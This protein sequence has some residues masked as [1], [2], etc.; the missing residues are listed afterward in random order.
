MR[1]GPIEDFGAW[2]E[3]AKEKIDG[4]IV[5]ASISGGKDSTAL[6]LLLNAAGIPY[7]A[8][9]MD[10]GWEH[11]DTEQYVRQYL[12][13]VLGK[14]IE[15][16]QGRHG[17][18]ESLI[19]KKGTF[20]SRVRRYCTQELKVRPMKKWLKSLD[21]EP[22]N[23]VGIRAAESR[24]RSKMPE[25]DHSA[26]FD[27]EVWRPL[28]DWSER[29]VINIHSDFGVLPNPLYL[30][31]ANRVGCWP[32]IF[33]RKKEIRF[34]ANTDPERIEKI[35]QLED[36][37]HQLARAR[38]RARNESLDVLDA[39]PPTWFH[40]R[41]AKRDANGK[42]EGTNWPIEKAVEWS[43]TSWGGK[44]FELFQADESDAGC[45]RWGLC[46]TV[47]ADGDMGWSKEPKE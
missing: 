37:V 18:M 45:M 34:I 4:R 9:H 19:R 3:K 5:C 21:D 33:A 26:G 11:E 15:I 2:T 46:E 25:W 17:G 42:I 10:T 23:V 38:Y 16:I 27:C 24:A 32:C 13:G 47:A 8:V 40:S 12:P 6:G 20:P 41:D 31:G 35:S 30:R 22:I 39:N 1:F 28:I 43:R 44:Q 36:E 7:R 29:D 14:D